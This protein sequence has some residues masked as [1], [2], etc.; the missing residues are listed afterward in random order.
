MT[1]GMQPHCEKSDGRETA[2]FVGCQ[3][4]KASPCS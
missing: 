3:P 1:S 4:L 2:G